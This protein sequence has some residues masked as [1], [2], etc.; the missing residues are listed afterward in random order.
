MCLKQNKTILTQR[1][2]IAGLQTMNLHPNNKNC[3]RNMQK[4][5]R[6]EF[7]RSMKTMLGSQSEQLMATKQ[8]PT[9]FTN[10]SDRP[11]VKTKTTLIT[12]KVRVIKTNTKQVL[13]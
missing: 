7:N 10:L 12:I 2:G 6:S 5:L 3:R 13:T 8:D 9:N 4:F 11:R 1:I